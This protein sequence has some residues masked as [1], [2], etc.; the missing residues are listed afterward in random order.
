MNPQQSPVELNHSPVARPVAFCENSRAV[1]TRSILTQ[2]AWFDS[3]RAIA[4]GALDG[5]DQTEALQ[6][7]DLVARAAIEAANRLANTVGTIP[8][9]TS[10]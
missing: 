7:I 5:G 10:L 8:T 6:S 4:A 1:I 3:I 9:A 2:G